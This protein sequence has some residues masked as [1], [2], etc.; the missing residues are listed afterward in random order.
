[1]SDLYLFNLKKVSQKFLKINNF[2]LDEPDFN[3]ESLEFF[4]KWLDDR[5][6][7]LPSVVKPFEKKEIKIRIDRRSVMSNLYSNDEG[8]KIFM[9]FLPKEGDNVSTN[10]AKKFIRLTQEYDAKEAVLIS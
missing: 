6:T 10:V 4:Q 8:G 3:T 1:M 5:L 2:E 9:F 7:I